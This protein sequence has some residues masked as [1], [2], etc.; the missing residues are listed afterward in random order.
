MSTAHN[1]EESASC[2]DTQPK[3]KNKYART[4][5]S[6]DEIRK[7]EERRLA[8]EKKKAEKKKAKEKKQLADQGAH[9][10]GAQHAQAQ[11]NAKK[12]TIPTV[13]YEWA[14]RILSG[15]HGDFA[16][17]ESGQS[18]VGTVYRWNGVYWDE[19]AQD[20]MRIRC[21]DWLFQQHP[22]KA[23]ASVSAEATQ[24]AI[25]MLGASKP[26]PRITDD[27]VMAV[28]NAYLHI[29]DSGDVLVQEPDA[30]LGLTHACKA[31]MSTPVGQVHIPQPVPENS[32]FGQYLASSVP[33]K[34]EQDLLQEMMAM[35]FIPNEYHKAIW[36][37]GSG[38]N[39][40]DVLSKINQAFHARP[41]V[42]KLHTLG[43]TFGLESIVGASLLVVNE[44]KRARFDEEVFKPLVSCD[45]V[46]VNRKHLKSLPVYYNQA[47]FLITAQDGPFITDNSNGV[48]ERICSME[49]KVVIPE[50]KRIPKLHKRILKE[51]PHIY[52]D[53]VL[54]GMKRL[55]A[56][57]AFPRESELPASVIQQKRQLRIQHDQVGAWIDEMGV[58][59]EAGHKM[60]KADVYADFQAW[61]VSDGREPVKPNVFWR[62]FWR[63]GEFA[64]HA[65][66]N[67][68]SQNTHG[69]RTKE[70]EV[71]ITGIANPLAGQS[72]KT[73]VIN[74]VS[75]CE[76]TF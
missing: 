20:R 56:R 49:F 32:L 63:K 8:V 40:K 21:S 19:V 26:L 24:Y 23:K 53:W 22:N 71:R 39:G 52:L 13:S 50:N 76:I 33:D 43:E 64:P 7:A 65:Q 58:E 67:L 28:Q 11:Q 31:F 29:N 30:S 69:Q 38:R 60:S 74:S 72:I 54:V 37:W 10:F 3:T 61:C 6:P 17:A 46:Q 75:D 73:P 18:G 12:E 36:L 57:G 35:T 15:L 1:R 27:H 66:K 45:P 70:V 4:P 68:Y 59:H 62:E 14:T 25:D 5:V 34:T 41:V 44:V 42:V 2:Q 51:E 55:L 47:V 48:H 9:S 16:Y